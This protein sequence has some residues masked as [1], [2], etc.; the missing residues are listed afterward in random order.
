MTVR[1][2]VLP[3]DYHKNLL[4]NQLLD[5]TGEKSV[6]GFCLYSINTKLSLG[7][8]MNQIVHDLD[9]DDDEIGH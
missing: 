9:S 8:V 1:E 5:P 4:D 2:R 7:R 6:N 3:S